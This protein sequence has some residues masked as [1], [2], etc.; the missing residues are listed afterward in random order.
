MS[1]TPAA[2]RIRHWRPLRRCSRAR[3]ARLDRARARDAARAREDFARA[4]AVND[5]DGRSWSGLGLASL[6]AQDFEGARKQLETAV[7]HM[8]GHIGTWHALGWCHIAGQRLDAARHCFE[9]ALALDRNF[10][11]S[12]GGLA[13]VAAMAGDRK[14]AEESVERALRLDPACLSAR[15][16]QS[17][18]SGEIRDSESFR[19]LAEALAVRARATW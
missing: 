8:P 5:K 17:L 19:R 18:L 7:K 9:Q 10:A 1:T 12:H 6:L 11:E 3:H 13:V 15:Y 16:A 2:W 14:G 4:L